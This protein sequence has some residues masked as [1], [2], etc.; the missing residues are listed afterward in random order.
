MKN[1]GSD[2]YKSLAWLLGGIGFV[3]MWN[4]LWQETLSSM[5]TSIFGGVVFG[6]FIGLLY[7]WY[8]SVLYGL[9][10]NGNLLKKIEEQLQP[11]EQKER[12]AKQKKAFE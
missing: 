10:Q 12:L 3:S 4:F 2:L 7:Y 6:S 5:T 11:K 9:E 1:Y 8:G